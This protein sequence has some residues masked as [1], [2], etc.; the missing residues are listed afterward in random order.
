V[1]IDLTVPPGKELVV[2]REPGPAPTTDELPGAI[3]FAFDAARRQ[4][5]ELVERQRGDVKVHPEQQMAGVIVRLLPDRDC[6]FIKT[7]DGRDVYFHRNSLLNEDF[8]R[9]EVGVGV[10]FA[11]EMGAHGLQASTVRVVDKPGARLSKSEEPLPEP[12]LGWGD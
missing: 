8:D 4:L 1:R 12:P 2:N 9:L 5:Q 6:G 11:E 7:L 10:H 3:R